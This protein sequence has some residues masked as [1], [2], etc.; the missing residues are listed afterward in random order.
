MHGT[1]LSLAWQAAIYL[2]VII[3][4]ARIGSYPAGLW[5]D[6]RFLLYGIL[7][8]ALCL[9]AAVLVGFS[10]VGA[11]LIQSDALRLL[12]A[13]CLFAVPVLLRRH[14]KANAIIRPKKIPRL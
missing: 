12:L 7:P 8:P 3:D 2:N 11:R 5:G 14:F 10:P 1:R 13:N 4:R 9:G 6:W